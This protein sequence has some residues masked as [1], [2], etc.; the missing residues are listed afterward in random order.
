MYAAAIQLISIHES[1]DPVAH[2]LR[3]RPPAPVSKRRQ[4]RGPTA[5]SQGNRGPRPVG[6]PGVIDACPLR[7]PLECVGFRRS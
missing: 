3:V 2:S 7:G 1:R 6:I 5:T 4:D